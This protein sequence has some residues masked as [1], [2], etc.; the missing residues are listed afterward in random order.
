M[1]RKML[2][3]AIS[4]A[5]LLT[6][7][8]ASTLATNTTRQGC[9]WGTSNTGNRTYEQVRVIEESL[10]GDKWL[11]TFPDSS[12]RTE[13]YVSKGEIHFGAECPGVISN[14][15]LPSQ[16]DAGFRSAEFR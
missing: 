7:G 12:D 9:T 16:F 8:C 4:V 14:P 11:V 5:A 10:E 2:I 15:G 3:I 1:F 6:T 13:R